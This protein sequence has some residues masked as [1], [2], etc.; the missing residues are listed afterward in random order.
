LRR[1]QQPVERGGGI[2]QHVHPVGDADLGLELADDIG[3][4]RHGDR[5][6]FGEVRQAELIGE[7]HRVGAAVL[8]GE[9]VETGAF[10]HPGDAS[11]RVIA[12]ITGQRLQMTHGDYGFFDPEELLDP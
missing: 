7:H 4:A 11:C 2:P 5:V 3:H 10:E 8:Y 9:Q 6:H 12:R 1:W